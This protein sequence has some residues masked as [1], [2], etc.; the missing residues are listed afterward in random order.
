MKKHIIIYCIILLLL[1]SSFIGV[2]KPIV[3]KEEH[4]IILSMNED[5]DWWPMAY[6][7]LQNTACSTSKAPNTNYS[8]WSYTFTDE[9]IGPMTPAVV[10][11]RLYFGTGT[12]PSLGKSNVFSLLQESKGFP[13]GYL[14][15]YIYCLDAYT[16]EKLWDFQTES[17]QL[18]PSVVDDSLYFVTFDINLSSGKLIGK[19]YCLNAVTGDES[20]SISI[21]SPPDHDCVL[22]TPV[23]ANGKI[24]ICE[25]YGG[26]LHC[27][28][29][30]NG[31]IIWSVDMSHLG[32]DQSS[33]TPAIVDGK[34]YVNFGN[35][36]EGNASVFCFDAET[37]DELWNSSISRAEYGSPAVVD[38]RVFANGF[39]R[40]AIDGVL[41]CFNSTSGDLIWK[42]EY[43]GAD[44]A[45]GWSSPAICN[46]K[47]Y[48]LSFRSLLC[49][50]LESGDLLWRE[51]YQDESL[52]SPSIA[53]GKI[54]FG[55]VKYR[56]LYCLNAENGSF[57]WSRW[58]ENGIVQT[59]PAIADG[60]VYAAACGGDHWID[61][62]YAF[63]DNNPPDAPSIN[64]PVQGKPGIDYN[65]TFVTND[66]DGDDI[67]YHIG[68][69]DKEIIYIYGPYPS[70]EEISLS[71]NWSE[72][73]TFVISCWARDIYDEVSD[74]STF[75]VTIP[76][77]KA[78][79]SNML[80]LRILERFPLLQKI[81]IFLTI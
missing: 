14:E 65:Y 29:A 12:L 61:G 45:I 16:G 44:N 25:Q 51:Y 81:S 28:N 58:L 23:V 70:G 46:N 33:K 11:G 79:T 54:Y 55:T 30:D 72:V 77:D 15:G 62:I 10:N 60:W 64:G 7:D 39:N 20:W 3:I 49:F 69:G 56:K 9:R 38:G 37:G 34:V 63:R 4:A 17:A 78:V 53:D 75:E 35:M 66:S 36:E 80:L 6:H 19:V 18:D 59:S 31:D 22:F 57:I 24:Y 42:S 74:V 5:I 50:D 41:F 13:R 2:S 52:S 68:W 27:L 47:V 67:F 73:G 32:Y 71:Y 8:C 21:D 76:R 1:F 48:V 40:S 26:K 43:G